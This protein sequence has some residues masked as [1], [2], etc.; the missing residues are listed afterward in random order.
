MTA[1][2]RLDSRIDMKDNYKIE[3]LNKEGTV[4]DVIEIKACDFFNDFFAEGIK[5]PCKTKRLQQNPDPEL[6]EVVGGMIGKIGTALQKF[7]NNKS[8]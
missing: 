6:R 5:R 8:D 4:A 7:R 2:K 3:R 1:F